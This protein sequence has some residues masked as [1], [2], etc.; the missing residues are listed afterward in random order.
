MSAPADTSTLNGPD[1]PAW[2]R[3]AVFYQV[4][5]ERFAN[6]DPSNDPPGTRPWGGKPTRSSTF[7]GDLQGLIDR[8]DH[9]QETGANAL[10]LTPIFEAPSTHKYDTSDYLKID[11]AFGTLETFRALV[12]AVHDRGMRIVLDAVFNHSGERH[13]AFRDAAKNGPASPY[14]HWYT[15][16]EHRVRTRPVPNYRH[17]GIHYIPTLNHANPEVR[18]HLLSVARYWT[19]EGIDGWRLDVPWYIEGETGHAFWREFRAQVRAINPQAY[20]V[21][22]HW[23]DASPWL[24]GDQFDGA[25][26]YQL[27]DAALAFSG[28]KIDGPELGYRLTRLNAL[29][30]WTARLSMFN[31]LGSHDT[32]RP[33][34]VL[35]GKDAAIQAALTLAFTFPGVPMLF[36][37][38]EIGLRGGKDPDCRRPF[39]W[40]EREWNR[41]TLDTVRALA[42]ARAASPALQAGSFTV[43]DAEKHALRYRRELDGRSVTVEAR[44][45]RP[46]SV[47]PD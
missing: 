8:L 27:R 3:S 12:R 41:A 46:S 13:W 28:G 43:L 33:A 44:R 2:V 22:E 39:P 21:G 42:A 30:P 37:G 19:N 23:G 34:T 6:G 31:L 10:Y 24:Q 20:I 26:D 45:D 17:A 35:R 40:D 11:P 15:F 14:W 38:D 7:G 25:T 4:F 1:V 47:T 32:P 29:Y 16:F 5:P 18:E 9:V 36:A